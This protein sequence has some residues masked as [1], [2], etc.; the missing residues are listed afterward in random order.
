MLENLFGSRTRSKILRLFYTKSNSRF[1][2]RELTRILNERI[3]SVRLELENLEKIGLIKSESS[4]NKKYY[5]LNTKFIL[6]NELKDLVVK[7]RFF[8][9]KEYIDKFKKLSGVKYLVLTGYFADVK[10]ETLTDVLVVGNTSSEKIEKIVNE[11]ADEFMTELNY[12]IMPVEEFNYRKNMTD[13]F[14]YNILKNKKIVVID[15]VS[16][17]I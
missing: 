8:L 14:L 11:M 4:D 16:T 10:D 6:F 5:S 13:R 12:T 9:E 7:S 1:F 2:V 3:N 17:E 15:K